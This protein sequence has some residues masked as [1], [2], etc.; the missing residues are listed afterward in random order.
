MQSCSLNCEIELPGYLVE[1]SLGPPH[2][3]THDVQ[4]AV[5]DIDLPLLLFVSPLMFV[6]WLLGNFHSPPVNNPLF[7]PPDQLPIFEVNTF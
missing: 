4:I 5:T 2:S 6:S 3:Q 1:D 7:L